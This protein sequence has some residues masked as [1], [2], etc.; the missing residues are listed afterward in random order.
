MD[1]CRYKMIIDIG[2]YAVFM[3]C[4]CLTKSELCAKWEDREAAPND[5]HVFREIQ[6]SGY[7]KC[8]KE[9]KLSTECA[10]I[11]FNREQLYCGLVRK[12][13]QVPSP[14]DLSTQLGP[15]ATISCGVDERCIESTRGPGVCINAMTCDGKYFQNRCFFEGHSSGDWTV[16]RDQCR[17]L[18]G[19]LVTIESTDVNSLI[20]TV[21][22]AGVFWVGGND[23]G[24]EG[25]WTWI[26]N[27]QQINLN[28]HWALR[29]PSV[30]SD[31]NCLGVTSAGVWIDVDCSLSAAYICQTY[32]TQ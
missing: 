2:V 30:A 4:V 31:V 20:L 17:Q 16:G 22:T 19:S 5:G 24:A 21:T 7:I 25:T 29:K 23:L 32:L 15:C 13:T 10:D 3:A 18:G 26:E 6:P 27:D 28:S 12:S 9:C 1:I 14:I 8:L 11:V